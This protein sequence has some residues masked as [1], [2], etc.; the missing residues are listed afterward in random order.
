MHSGV[1]G[2]LLAEG[3][4]ACDRRRNME[5]IDSRWRKLSRSPDE[6]DDE[7]EGQ[8]AAGTGDDE[9]GRGSGPSGGLGSMPGAVA[10]EFV[11]DLAIGADDEAR[12]REK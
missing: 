1:G 8:A 10:D 12:P 11:A 7:V 9:R 2:E 5:E 6:C 4:R 3:A